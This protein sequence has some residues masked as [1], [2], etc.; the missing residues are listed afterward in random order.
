MS[1]QIFLLTPL[2]FCGG[3]QRW[4]KKHVRWC[5]L[6]DWV[7]IVLR[8]NVVHSGDWC[9]DNLS[10][11]CH[12]SQAIS[13]CQSNVPRL[14]CMNWLVSFAVMILAVRLKWQYVLSCHKGETEKK[15]W[16]P[17]RNQTLDLWIWHRKRDSVVN[18]AYRAAKMIT[19]T[20][21]IYSSRRLGRERTLY[22][23]GGR[24]S[25]EGK[26]GRGFPAHPSSFHCPHK[27][28]VTQGQLD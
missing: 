7:S 21:D 23:E 24:Q 9:Y 1:M 16:V 28:V 26:G 5:S 4:M 18:S 20:F 14:V 13:C 6:I 11:S 27:L 10:G 3:S 8:R 17:M 2:L 25:L 19:A 15:F 12:Q 22:Q